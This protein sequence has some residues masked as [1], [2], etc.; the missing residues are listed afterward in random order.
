MDKLKLYCYV[1]ETGPDTK[2]EFFLVSVIALEGELREATEAS[3]ERIETRTKKYNRKWRGTKHDIRIDYLRDILQVKQLSGSI[4]YATY[5][6]Q[7]NYIP[8][9]AQTIIKVILRWLSASVRCKRAMRETTPSTDTTPSQT[10]PPVKAYGNYQA[11]II[12]D[13]INE[14]EQKRVKRL[15]KESH[16]R[17]KKV[18]GPKDESTALLRLADAMAGFL[19]DYHE[20]KDYT[21]KLY[22]T[23]QRQEFIFE[24]EG[25][26]QASHA[27]K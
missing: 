16:I 20:R 4:F 23:F 15:L 8:L 22:R 12:I 11:T 13:G 5:R 17:Y 24:M 18:K 14:A 9:I 7:T 19:R 21:D 3:L 6:G 27:V 2:G 10:S 26:S 1:D 25:V